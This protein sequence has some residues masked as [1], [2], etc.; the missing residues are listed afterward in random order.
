MTSIL[1]DDDDLLAYPSKNKFLKSNRVIAVSELEEKYQHDNIIFIPDGEYLKLDFLPNGIINKTE[2]GIGGTTV[3][4]KSKRNSIIVEPL[5]SIAAT[6]AMEH[7]NSLYVGSPTNL[8]NNAKRVTDNDIISYHSSDIKDKKIFVVADSLPRL[9]K[10]IGESVYKEYFLLI[11][12][13]DSYQEDSAFR[14]NIEKCID[15]YNFFPPENRALISA[16]INDFSNPNLENEKLT[17]YKYKNPRTRRVELVL[18]DNVERHT[19]ETIL[20]LY[21][22]GQKIVI[23]YNVLR[24]IISIIETL[25]NDYNID[26]EEFGVL[27]GESSEVLADEF[28]RD[29]EN[30]L[31]PSRIT[32]K[33]S[34][35]FSGI[36]INEQYHLISVVNTR[37]PFTI[38]SVN[39]FKQIAGRCRHKK[40]LLSETIIFND[41]KEEVSL[42]P[43][44]VDSLIKAAQIDL[45]VFNC[46][47]KLKG[48]GS[49]KKYFNLKQKIFEVL[50]GK[51]P[52]ALLRINYK[53][54]YDISYFKIDRLLEI[55]KTQFI[56]SMT[57]L[58]GELE[59]NNVKVTKSEIY[60]G[61]RFAVSTSSGF[62]ELRKNQIKNAIDTLSNLEEPTSKNLRKLIIDR[63]RFNYETNIYKEYEKVFGFVFHKDFVEY[64]NMMNLPSK[65]NLKEFN[66]L[67]MKLWFNTL[68]PDSKFKKSL[69]KVFVNG[70]K[71]KPID[72]IKHLKQI[73]PSQTND[74]SLISLFNILFNTK[75]T[76][77]KSENEGYINAYEILGSAV[78]E[79]RIIKHREEDD[80]FN[81]KLAT[82]IYF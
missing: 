63:Q 52:D 65:S 14:G 26:K 12:E 62:K 78:P 55:H 24:P 13:I 21:G 3:E 29:F 34:A 47:N 74:D 72:I 10:C 41:F 56:Y 4:A 16:T 5:K 39:K 51:S 35:Y 54:E 23:A 32:F 50:G 48:K 40:K 71:Y 2:T 76:K 68:P 61:D 81:S 49:D 25:I 57:N 30:N 46:I 31:L 53:D 37:I 17:I 70:E 59:R 15:Y 75:R 38:L 19:I 27:C 6:K 79:I 20:K 64:L 22:D 28:Y 42:V 18:T 45:S 80:G 8:Y 82:S 73:D 58:R 77:I 1:N 9:I 67:I 69:N 44:T 66:N 43:P 36:D 60:Y 7:K 33:T 11:D